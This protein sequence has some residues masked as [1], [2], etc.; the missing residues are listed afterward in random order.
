[1]VVV[2][3]AESQAP[4]MMMMVIRIWIRVRVRNRVVVGK[5]GDTD[6]RSRRSLTPIWVDVHGRSLL[7]RILIHFM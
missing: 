4:V 3:A 6:N 5:S 1:V 7:V 2:M